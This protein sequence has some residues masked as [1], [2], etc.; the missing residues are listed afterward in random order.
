MVTEEEIKKVRTRLLNKFFDSELGQRMVAYEK[1][2]K[3]IKKETYYMEAVP[4]NLINPDI[5][6][7]TTVIMQGVIDAYFEEEDG[8]IL[9]DYKSDRVQS[10]REMAAAKNIFRK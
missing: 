2:G 8:Y 1:T 7:D 10:G 6:D 9:V 5:E 3:R 4:A